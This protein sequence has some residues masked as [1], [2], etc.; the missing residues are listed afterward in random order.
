MEDQIVKVHCPRLLQ[1]DRIGAVNLGDQG[2]FGI[3]R[4][5]R[6]HIFGRQQLI[7][8][9]T[10][11]RHRRLDRQELVVDHLVLVDLLEHPLL[12]V[13][14][15]DR[16]APGEAD[17][18]R[19][20]AQDAHTGGVEGGGVHIPAHRL[21]QHG[22]QA[23]FQFPGRLVGKGDGQHVPGPGRTHRQIRRLPREIA[24]GLHRCAQ[25]L[26]VLFGDG[27]RQFPAAVSRAK[28]DDIGD[29]VDQHRCF[30]G[31]GPGQDQQRPLGGENRLPLY[32]VEVAEAVFDILVAQG[33][34]FT[35]NIGHVRF[36][37]LSNPTFLYV[38]S[39]IPP[40][41]RGRAGSAGSFSRP[42]GSR[43][44]TRPSG[45]SLRSG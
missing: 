32:R 45:V 29:A 44:G 43:P 37:S 5:L 28:T 2:R 35:G 27:A 41:Q 15:I 16:K 12:V 6:R 4:G 17:A 24:A 22:A 14:V 38:Y 10:D 21:A 23:L 1:P 3:P 30:A 11:L 20:P 25:F 18:L 9:G 19:V 31:T 26:Q 40:A 42:W 39:L 33:D 34:I 13:G 36:P 7:L 8:E